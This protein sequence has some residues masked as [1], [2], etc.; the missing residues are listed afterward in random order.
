MN[1]SVDRII[2]IK[3]AP[4][5]GQELV[6]FAIVLPLL[7]LFLFGVFDLGRMF[8]AV[9]GIT[10]AAREGARYYTLNF[11]KPDACQDGIE[12]AVVAEGEIYGIAL[13]VDMVSSNCLTA[14]SD[15]PIQVT[16]TYPFTWYTAIIFPD[17]TMDITR[18]AQMLVP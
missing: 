3:N 14:T 11:S 12:E 9:I 16:V 2:R 15:N 8:H 4:P 17:P 1:C 5:R 10:N 6:E 7:F 13:A 18:S